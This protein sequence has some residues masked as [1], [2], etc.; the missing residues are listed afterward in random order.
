M[1]NHFNEN[2]QHGEDI[3]FVKVVNNKFIYV[4]L[5]EINFKYCIRTK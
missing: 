3:P 4:A 1:F 2:S 5:P